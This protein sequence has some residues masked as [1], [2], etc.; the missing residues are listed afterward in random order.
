[1][2]DWQILLQRWGCV[3]TERHRPPVTGI[4]HGVSRGGWAADTVVR[5]LQQRDNRYGYLRSAK[6][7]LVKRSKDRRRHPRFELRCRACR[8]T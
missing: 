8:S 3:L 5:Q 4:F 7:K 6:H 1:M 2:P